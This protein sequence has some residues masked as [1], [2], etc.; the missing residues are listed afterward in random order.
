MYRSKDL[1]YMNALKGKINQLTFNADVHDTFDEV[2]EHF[3]K[4][5]VVDDLHTFLLAEHA[6][7]EIE[8]RPQY[9][10]NANLNPDFMFVTVSEHESEIAILNAIINKANIQ[11]YY[12]TSYIKHNNFLYYKENPHLSQII[13]NEINIVKP[14]VVIFFGLNICNWSIGGTERHKEFMFNNV[15]VV[16]TSS[17]T[18]LL[19]NDKSEQ[20]KISLKH[21]I[22]GDIT[23]FTTK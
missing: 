9:V 8:H 21:Y 18:D 10:Y 19:S 13:K 3:K 20:D 6:N 12:R 22:W 17:L 16:A 14:K 15:P 4:Y 5:I 23:K 2:W 11:S 7:K 1:D